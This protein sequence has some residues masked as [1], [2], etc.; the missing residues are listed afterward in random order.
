METHTKRVLRKNGRPYCCGSLMA[1]QP[2]IARASDLPEDSKKKHKPPNASSLDF[3][4]RC[5]KCG[6]WFETG[7]SV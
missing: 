4:A 2:H 7:K 1:I 6:N 3:I 5:T